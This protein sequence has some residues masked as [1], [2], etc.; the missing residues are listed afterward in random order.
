MWR[1][2]FV[3]LGPVSGKLSRFLLM[4]STVF[5]SLSFLLLPQSITCIF[6]TLFIFLHGTYLW[7]TL[8]ILTYAFNSLYLM[9]F[10]TSFSSINHPLYLYAWILILFHLTE[11]M[12]S[13]STHLL[14][15]LLLETLMSFRRT[16]LPILAELMDLVN[17]VMTLL[18]WLTILVGSLIVTL[19]ILFWWIYF[20]RL[21]FYKSLSS[22][23]KFWLCCCLSL[24]WLSIK[25]KRGCPVSLYSL[26]LFL[27]W[28]GRSS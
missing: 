21:M 20:Y 10:F 9:Q 17:F 11:M 4:V 14:M 23:G 2:N 18:S 27:C 12:L 25:L 22:C 28:L 1:K 19:R 26:W 24:H 5:T 15:F 8:Q 7:K 13:W 6:F 3:C 16:S